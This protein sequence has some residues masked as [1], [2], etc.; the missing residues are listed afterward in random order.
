MILSIAVAISFLLSLSFGVIGALTLAIL[1]SAFFYI[2]KLPLF[3]K[4]LLFLGTIIF[5]ASMIIIGFSWPENPVFIR[6]ENIL[7]GVDT[8]A[9][10]RLVNSF[11][12]AWDLAMNYNVIF[13]VGPGQIKILAHDF[14][15]NFY[16]YSGTFAEVVRIPNSMG[17]ML[18]TYGLFGFLFKLGIEIY[19]F[20][21][22][23]I[24]ANLYSL[25]LFI[26]I[27]IYQFTGSFLINIAEMGIWAIVFQSRFQQFDFDKIKNI[28]E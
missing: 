15:I 12:F 21:R 8:S 17:E 28:S 26:F 22:L 27:F 5:S 4:R 9:K 1:I 25:C 14:I 19:F 7:S 6:I 2:K 18:A 24:Y 11:M 20:A 10:G 3:S 23:R 16:Q 13:G